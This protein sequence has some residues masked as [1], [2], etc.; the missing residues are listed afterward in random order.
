MPTRFHCYRTG[1][2]EENSE[3]FEAL[4]RKGGGVFQCFGEADLKAA[5]QAHR[6]QCLQVQRVRFVGGPEASDIL[7]SGR[8]AAVY[9]DGE[10]VVAARFNGT[11][12]TTVIVEG[13]FA[14]KKMVQEF[15]L[16]VRSASELAARPGR[17][18]RSPRCWRC[19]IAIS[20]R[21]V[22]AYCQQFGIVS[23]VASFLVLE[24]EADYKRFNL[25]EERGKTLAGDLGVFLADMWTRLGKAVPAGKAFER[26]LTQVDKRVNLLNGPN[27]AHV[28][29]MLA[30]LT[31]ADFELPIEPDPRR[32]DPRHGQGR[33][34]LSGG[35]RT[36]SS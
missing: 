8:R 21:L 36:G 19:T 10:L 6:S 16:E 32:T 15:P 31:E 27:G 7:V 30:L 4:T 17:K 28:K 29:Q 23:R 35:T 5:A 20:M 11:G 33:C 26:F 9:P 22:T 12:R 24:N 18:W 25:E 14:G 34:R 2:G 1:L 3:L 13:E